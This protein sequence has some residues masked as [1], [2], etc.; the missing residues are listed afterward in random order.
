MAANAAIRTGSKLGLP[1]D[2]VDRATFES[3]R[4]AYHR[5]IRDAYLARHAVE[6]TQEH[7]VRP[8]ESVWFLAERRYRIP[9]WLLR[10]YNP[11]VDLAAVRPGA[12]VVIP[13]VAR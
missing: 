1:F 10:E 8:G 9:V 13:R 5:G 4:L 12:R 6:G 7:L 11:G 3:R 2:K